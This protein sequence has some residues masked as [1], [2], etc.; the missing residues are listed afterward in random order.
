MIRLRRREVIATAAGLAPGASA[1]RAAE[2][3]WRPSRPMRIVVPAPPGGITDIGA[4]LAAAQFQAAWGVPVVVDNRAG[5]GGIIGTN[6]FLR[7]PADGH[8]LLVGN[9]GPQAIAYTLYRE[10]PYTA[11]AFAPVSGLIRGPN[12]LVLHPSVPAASLPEFVNLLRA[13]PRVLN[14]G[15]SGTGQSSG[16]SRCSGPRRRTC[17]SAAPH[18]H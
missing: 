16:S 11:A 3:R 4:R 17:R 5:G 12:V 9:I 10:L 2:A 7:A 8:T 1:L 6:D 14:Y 15:S 18:P 13:R